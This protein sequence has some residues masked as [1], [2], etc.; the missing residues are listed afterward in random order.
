[1]L[2]DWKWVCIGYKNGLIF[3][4]ATLCFRVLFT[5]DRYII[6]YFAGSDPLGVYVLYMSM[7]TAIISFMDPAVFSF[8]YPRLVSAYRQRKFDAYKRI[9]KELAFS[10]I[11]ASL[12]LAI[13]FATSAPWILHWTGKLIY[14]NQLPVLWMLL[15]MAIIYTIGMVPHY[16]LYALGADKS[17]LFTHISSLAIFIT[18]I[19]LTINFSPL[20]SVSLSLIGA[21]LWMAGTKMWLYLI[22]KP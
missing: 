11:I 20:Y 21:F 2:I 13:I 7:A 5:A 9:F 22:F 4:I 15:L 12:L 16:A 3:L 17:I 6:K 1:L 8:L 19:T 14:L 18:I 10:S